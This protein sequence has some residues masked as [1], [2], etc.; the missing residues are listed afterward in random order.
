MEKVIIWLRQLKI[1][2][3]LKYWAHFNTKSYTIFVPVFLSVSKIEDL[4]DTI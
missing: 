4:L 1:D 3:S 2:L